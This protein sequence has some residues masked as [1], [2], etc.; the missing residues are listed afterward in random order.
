M[1]RLTGKFH[2]GIV[3]SA[4]CLIRLVPLSVSGPRGAQKLLSDDDGRGPLF[5]VCCKLSWP[6]IYH[7]YFVTC[8]VTCSGELPAGTVWADGQTVSSGRFLGGFGRRSYLA[9]VGRVVSTQR[10][11]TV[12]P[13]PQK[14]VFKAATQQMKAP[15]PGLPA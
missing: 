1:G 8:F 7:K 5:L 3:R 11:W 10:S 9:R 12:A 4:V 15:G 14:L 6:R 2:V 13:S